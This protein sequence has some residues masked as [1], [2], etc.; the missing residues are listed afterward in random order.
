[1]RLHA[2]LVQAE[3]CMQHNLRL[4][5]AHPCSNSLHHTL[6]SLSPLFPLQACHVTDCRHVSLAPPPWACGR[7]CRHRVRGM[8]QAPCRPAPSRTTAPRPA[9]PRAWPR[10]PTPVLS[11]RHSICDTAIVVSVHCHH[12]CGFSS[13]R[14]LYW[15]WCLGRRM[16]Q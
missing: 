14:Q 12:R 6:S 16:S 7:Q 8:R 5:V 1:M 2:R 9:G 10:I 15:Q 11:P 4:L 3:Q 13:L